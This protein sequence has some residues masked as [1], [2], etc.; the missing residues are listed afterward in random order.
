LVLAILLGVIA[1]V[2]RTVA[3]DYG[4]RLLSEGGR[5]RRERGLFTRTEAVIAKKR[6]QLAMVVSGPLRGLFGWG[7]LS[8]QTLGA[9]SDA[10]GLQAAAPFAKRHEMESI[11]AEA[12]DYRLPQ[13]PELRMVSS[14]HI[15]R[16]LAGSV[17]PALIAVAAAT[18]F[19]P[20]AIFLLGAIPLIGAGAALQRRFHR[21][22]LEGDLL[23]ISRGVWR[24]QLWVLPVA[25]IQAIS[26]ARSW[27]QRRLG[28]ATVSIDTAGAPVMN[29]AHIVDLRVGTAE[30]LA[31]E[32]AAGR[33]LHCSGRKSGT[34]R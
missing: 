11:L 33:R 16:A 7:G 23:F 29:G 9:A 5:F 30:A 22:A 27:L 2:V 15:V 19:F 25:N 34:D 24:Q 8:F 4:Y 26:V 13:P 1:G 12:G 6:V 17:A 20:P 18:F 10:S 3:R 14:R 31:G 21:Y 32:L 28:L